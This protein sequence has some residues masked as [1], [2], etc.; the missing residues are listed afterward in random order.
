MRFHCDCHGNNVTIGMRHE[1]DP[2]VLMNLHSK[3]GLNMTII[4]IIIQMFRHGDHHASRGFFDGPV[5]KK[6]LVKIPYINTKIMPK[7]I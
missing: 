1:A 7:L 6:L 3:H 2:I 5:V 4:I